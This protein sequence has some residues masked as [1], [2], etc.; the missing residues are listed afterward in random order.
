MKSIFE[1]VVFK[2]S[3]VLRRVSSVRVF[4]KCLEFFA[5]FSINTEVFLKGRGVG[6]RVSF[7]LKDLYAIT[8]RNIFYFFRK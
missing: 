3:G 8:F 2:D 6:E 7:R 1:D 4:K 5:G